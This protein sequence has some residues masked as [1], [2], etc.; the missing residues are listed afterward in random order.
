[1]DEPE[2]LP[3]D[4]HVHT[5]SRSKTASLLLPQHL[6]GF[7]QQQIMDGLSGWVVSGTC[8]WSDPSIAK[9]GFYPRGCKSASDKLPVYSKHWAAVEIDTSTYALPSEERIT[10][11]AKATP[12]GF[13]FSIKAPGLF[14]NRSWPYNAVPANV[15]EAFAI[16]HASE[17]ARVRL[18][19]VPLA[20][21]DEIWGR[22]NRIVDRLLHMK[23]LGAVVFQFNRGFQP[24]AETA[25]YVCEC[26]RRL[27]VGAPMAVE[28]RA[29]S[30]FHGACGE[31]VPAATLD[32]PP[33]ASAISASVAAGPEAAATSPSRSLWAKAAFNA[34]DVVSAVLGAGWEGL[35]RDMSGVSVPRPLAAATL[36]R[37]LSGVSAAAEAGTGEAL[38]F[39][40]ANGGEVVDLSAEPV[41]LSLSLSESSTAT[42][43]SSAAVAAASPSCPATASAAETEAALASLDVTATDQGPPAIAAAASTTAP[44]PNTQMAATLRLLRLL[45][46]A[47]V[48]SDDLEHEMDVS[49]EAVPLAD[50]RTMPIHLHLT[51]SR[52]AY[53][54]VH[55]RVGRHRLLSQQHL[56]RWAS[57]LQAA[58]A[59]ANSA[60]P[61]AASS[62]APSSCSA[63][64]A[65]QTASAGR[66]C[67]VTAAARPPVLLLMWGTDWERQPLMN[68]AALSALVPGLW[69]EWKTKQAA[70]LH[71]SGLG[72]FFGSTTTVK[73][74]MGP[75]MTGARVSTPER[76]A[77]ADTSTAARPAS[78]PA[79][80]ALPSPAK[81]Q[82]SPARNAASPGKSPLLAAFARAKQTK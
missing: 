77:T 80:G 46:V 58:F 68:D 76:P 63:S 64:A 29:H 79:H 82:R 21:L 24:S 31:P 56:R 53:A 17:T 78:A 73:T 51:S 60:H 44:A 5:R 14:P 8:S 12:P 70:K 43:G 27:H 37:Q 3:R 32:P 10:Q 38:S 41:P 20:A 4:L 36:L 47:L 62:P 35:R 23:K 55:R 26:R 81:R 40:F 33:L 72:R 16:P 1:M 9:T 34:S 61:P 39:P 22:F 52:L 11:W 48:A 18:E 50:S 59:L 74:A 54:R 6:E 57:R 28:F 49:A 15:R 69:T 71:K 42:L 19:D 7:S 67:P 13:L 45:D 25:R 75:A 2:Q 65:T 30:W 66:P